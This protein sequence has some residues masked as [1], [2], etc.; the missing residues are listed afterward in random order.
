MFLKAFWGSCK[1]CVVSSGHVAVWP[2]K[3]L[4]YQ[5]PSTEEQL[6]FTTSDLNPYLRSVNGS[7]RRTISWS[8]ESHFITAPGSQG[9]L[10]MTWRIFTL[11]VNLFV[12]ETSWTQ[13]ETFDVSSAKTKR[14]NES[15][16]LLIKNT[17]TSWN[18]FSSCSAD[19]MLVESLDFWSVS[20]REFIYWFLII[21]FKG[22][23]IKV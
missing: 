7:V 9:L 8:P 11:C 21:L 6:C 14:W 15:K 13:S 17:W 2:K 20:D 3:F 5:F 16:P 18:V 23:I 19:S 1:S 22:L 10:N 4:L 12:W